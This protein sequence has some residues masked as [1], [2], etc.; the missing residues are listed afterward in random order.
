MEYKLENFKILNDNTGL[1]LGLGED[2]G[3]IKYSS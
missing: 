1:R 2:E 3:E